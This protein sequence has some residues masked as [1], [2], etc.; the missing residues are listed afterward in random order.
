M[1][2]PRILTTLVGA[3]ALIAAMLAFAPAASADHR[4]CG[5]A[6]SEAEL[7]WQ[8]DPGCRLTFVI[9][10]GVGQFVSRVTLL[11][12]ADMYRQLGY[13]RNFLLWAAERRIPGAGHWWTH[14]D[15]NGTDNSCADDNFREDGP[16]SNTFR[17][18]LEPELTVFGDAGGFIARVC[19]NSKTGVSRLNHYH[20]S[21]NGGKFNDRNRDGVRQAGEE[22]LAG[23][24]FEIQQVGAAYG[25]P[26]GVV[27]HATTGPDGRWRFDLTHASPGR[28]RITEIGQPDWRVTTPASIEID[29]HE[30]AES[31]AFEV[32]TWGNTATTADVAKTA[33]SVVDPPT[34]I[35]ADTPTDVTVRVALAN[36]GPAES[37]AVT[38]VV[39]WRSPNRDCTVSPGRR[40]IPVVLR[41]G[42]PVVRDVTMTITCTEPSDHLVSFVDEL[43]L[44]EPGFRDPVPGNNSAET[45]Y[46]FEVFDASD[47]VV[48]DALLD[49]PGRTDVDVPV[50]CTA[51]ATLTNSGPYGPTGTDADLAIEVPADCTAAV[52]SGTEPERVMVEVGG[53]RSVSQ[54]W[55]VECAD[56]SFHPMRATVTGRTDHRHV[57]DRVPGNNTATA[58]DVVE[59]FESADLAVH[60]SDLRCDE[61]EADRTRSACTATVEVTNQGVADAVQAVATT[62][63][64]PAA[65]CTVEPGA[66]VAERLTLAVGETRV[67]TRDYRLSCTEAVRH[68]VVVEAEVAA[69]EPHAEDRSTADN[70]DLLRWLPTDA[71]PRSLPS[72]VNLGKQGLLPFALLST[73]RVDAVAEVDT[74][75]VRYGVTGTEDSVI[76]CASGGEDVDDDGRADLV[77]QA[78]TPAT[79]ITCTTTQLVATGRL[80]DGTRFVSQDEVKVTGCR[81]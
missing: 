31:H 32:G 35:N 61:R 16:V 70:H 43:A 58:E 12:N 47:L 81:A 27:G 59:V 24:T 44:V 39:T 65:D 46:A 41:V 50:T 54:S 21:L 14:C 53:S 71:K 49:C 74:G 33:F 18:H 55:T 2:L 5:G 78:D 57:E 69:D 4:G 72:S 28:Y 37:V 62:W 66:Q 51:K 6:R 25:A 8:N 9:D 19:G 3:L 60:I 36:N 73:E 30:G 48:T 15:N 56:R 38:D 17:D 11:Q 42:T 80:R 64:V 29:V 40:E 13:D 67:L 34:R 26:A 1:R 75:T 68:D 22:P 52:V 7:L 79:G 76:R 77:C 20:P 23:W 63:A 45:D 10:P